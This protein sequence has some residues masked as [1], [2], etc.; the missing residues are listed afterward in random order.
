VYGESSPS[1][2]TVKDWA[3]QF[4]LG[5]ESI[6]DDPRQGRPAEALTPETTT[7]VQEE[8]YRIEDWKQRK[9]QKGVGFQ[10]P[11][12][13]EFHVTIFVW[14]RW[15]QDGCRNSECCRKA[16]MCSM[17]HWIFNTLQRARE[18]SNRVN[19]H[20]RWNYGSV[21]WSPA[22][23]GLDGLATSGITMAKK[24]RQHNPEKDHGHHFLGLLGNSA[25]WLQRAK[26]YRHWGIL[27]H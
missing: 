4:H 10:K 12:Y 1:Y 17:L 2:S 19:C 21:P 3:K 11:R 16:T 8:C 22:Q 25:S 26:Y 9:C 13:F 23:K 7:L 24:Q 14:I 27:C 6:E 20:G 15:V 5:R 18:R